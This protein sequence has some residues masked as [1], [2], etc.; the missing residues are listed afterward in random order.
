MTNTN[1]NGRAAE[2]AASGVDLRPAFNARLAGLAAADGASVGERATAERAGGVDDTTA[3]MALSNFAAECSRAASGGDMAAVADLLA[4]IESGRERAEQTA[5]LAG[6][7]RS[8]ADAAGQASSTADGLRGERDGLRALLAA[9]IENR[10]RLVA[11]LERATL[12]LDVVRGRERTARL[13]AAADNAR[14]EL[15]LDRE[16][17]AKRRAADRLAEQAA[18]GVATWGQPAGVGPAAG[19]RAW[20]QASKW[21]SAVEAVAKGRATAEQVATF[22]RRAVAC[23]RGG[24]AVRTGVAFEIA[25]VCEATGCGQAEFNRASERFER[26]AD[27]LP[28]AAGPSACGRSDCRG[29]CAECDPDDLP[30]VG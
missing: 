21:A 22:D 9:E 13:R 14:R 28:V 19:V 7:L 16:R 11:E 10:E 26:I 8:A 5:S 30:A 4:R 12:E 2:A 6:R 29:D 3:R 24:R 17:L 23:M 1:T 25:G 15:A 27:G 20:G 18:A